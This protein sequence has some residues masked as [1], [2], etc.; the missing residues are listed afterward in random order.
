MANKGPRIGYPS[1]SSTE[2]SYFDFKALFMV[3]ELFTPTFAASDFWMAK[4]LTPFW[5]I[6]V[7]IVIG[8][9]ILLLFLGLCALLIVPTKGLDKLRKDGSLNYLALGITGVIGAL[10]ALF[11]G[12]GQMRQ[13]FT[14]R[15]EFAM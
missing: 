14:V 15:G 5:F 10:I 4:W 11:L 8:F 2:L 9:A 13:S 6:G 1:N 3:M 12:S 7:G